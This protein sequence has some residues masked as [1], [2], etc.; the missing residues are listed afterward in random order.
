[1]RLPI[2]YAMLYPERHVN[3]NIK[4]LDP[5][6]TGSLTFERWESERYPCF[7]LAIEVARRGGTWPS[8]L[9]G[10]NDAAVELFLAGKI[11]FM[12]IGDAIRDGLSEHV[13]VT[14]PDLDDIITACRDAN[15]RVAALVGA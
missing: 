7:D 9:S 12:E 11:G 2:Q 5:V 10:A 8:A 1:M 13:N 15:G 4:R 6:A 3:P 14:D